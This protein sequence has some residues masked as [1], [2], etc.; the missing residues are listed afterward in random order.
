MVAVFLH[1]YLGWL[2][3]G[4]IFS[5]LCAIWIWGNHFQ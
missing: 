5:M 1:R 3:A 2:I 4:A